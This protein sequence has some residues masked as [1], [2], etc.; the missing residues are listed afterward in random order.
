MCPKMEDGP[1]G[2]RWAMFLPQLCFPQQQPSLHSPDQK[3]RASPSPLLSSP[4]AGMPMTVTLLGT[5]QE[6]QSQHAAAQTSKRKDPELNPHPLK[7]QALPAA[8]NLTLPA[9]V[10]HSVQAQCWT[11]EA[12]VFPECQSRTFLSATDLKKGPRHCR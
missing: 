12:H 8:A 1:D 7:P 6:N 5:A 11:S 2:N 4:P 10:W 9:V 3:T